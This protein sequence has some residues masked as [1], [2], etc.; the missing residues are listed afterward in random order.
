LKRARGYVREA[1]DDLVFVLDGAALLNGVV[2]GP[3][4]VISFIALIGGNDVRGRRYG[5]Y[6]LT[7]SSEAFS[8]QVI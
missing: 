6:D 1:L 3:A 2:L 7:S 4:T 5:T 8:L